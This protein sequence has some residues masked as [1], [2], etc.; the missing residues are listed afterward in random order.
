MMEK[1][2]IDISPEDNMSNRD[3]VA[4]RQR[5]NACLPEWEGI[6]PQ[7]RD[8]M[9]RFQRNDNVQ[10]TRNQHYVPKFWQKRF[11]DSKRIVVANLNYSLDDLRFMRETSIRRAARVRDLYNV[12]SGGRI[13]S[14]YEEY[15]AYLENHVARLFSEIDQQGTETLIDNPFSRWLLSQFLTVSNMRTEMIIN[16]TANRADEMKREKEKELGILLPESTTQLITFQALFGREGLEDKLAFLLFCRHWTIIPATGR[17]KYTLPLH[18]II[19]WGW[20][21]KVATQIWVPLDRD[22]LLCLHWTPNIIASRSIANH[23]QICSDII[24]HTKAHADGRM[25][26]HPEDKQYWK[27][28]I[29]YHNRA[30]SGESA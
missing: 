10:L 20:G 26:V 14:P 11:A 1:I 29:K 17:I 25:I 5:A 7:V 19:N 13:H 16:S 21:I 18:P 28:Q 8:F 24:N 9:A 6:V 4:M 12:H 23:R 27:K 22:K 30:T 3:V 15:F 2:T